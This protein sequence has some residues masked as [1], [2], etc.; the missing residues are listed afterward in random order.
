MNDPRA[1][2]SGYLLAALVGGLVGGLA[3]TIITKLVPK[4]KMISRM[5]AEGG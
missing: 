1:D 4:I 3:V 5:M 2:R